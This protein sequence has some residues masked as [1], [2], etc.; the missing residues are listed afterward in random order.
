[1]YQ[2]ADPGIVPSVCGAVVSDDGGRW[3]PLVF[4]LGISLFRSGAISLDGG[5]AVVSEPIWV[6]RAVATH[7]A[8]MIARIAAS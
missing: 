3:Q 7:A 4:E 8:I 1:M 6:C 2:L 5:H